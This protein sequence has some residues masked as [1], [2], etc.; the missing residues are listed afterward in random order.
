MLLSFI[1]NP[2]YDYDITIGFDS[3]LAVPAFVGD[4]CY[5]CS[6]RHLV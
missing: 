4:G 3:E 5:D 6:L 1:G 2:A